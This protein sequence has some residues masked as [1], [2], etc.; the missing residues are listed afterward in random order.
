MES[1]VLDKNYL[2]LIQDLKQK[3]LDNSKQIA[4]R[5]KKF[6]IV[7]C[8]N[9]GKDILRISETYNG[10]WL[11]H[12]FDAVV[13][14]ELFPELN[15]ISINQIQT[16]LSLQLEDGHIP[17]MV[18]L[19]DGKPIAKYSQIQECYSFVQVCIKAIEQNDCDKEQILKIYNALCKWDNWYEKFRM[20]KDGLFLTFC[21][22]DTGHDG[23][24]RLKDYDKY[25]YNFEPTGCVMPTD[26]AVLPVISLDN[27]AVVY[28]NRKGLEQ[29]ANSLG[30]TEQ[31]KVWQTKAEKLKNALL[32]TCYDPKTDFYYDVDKNGNF[33]DIKS[34]SVCA[35]FMHK[36]LGKEEGKN[37]FIKYFTNPNYFGT[38]YPYPSVAVCDPLFEKNSEG[39]SWNYFAQGLT[40][41]RATTWME[42]YG[43]EQYQTLNMQKWLYSMTVNDQRKFA[44][45]LDPFTGEPSM[46]S[47]YYSSSMLYYLYCAKKLFS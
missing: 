18:G 44:Q 12:A 30:L 11:E 8:F 42:Y 26:N 36:V 2:D 38:E 43:L 4:D 14:A 25:K 6:N 10:L 22:Y 17:F 27:N 34:I 28:G 16:F 32:K 9:N 46:Y 13:F 41:L 3:I 15:H 47:E 19:N 37:F 45:E 35:L 1:V 21:G 40:M 29:F 23:S 33:I 39:N 7:D 5:L 20:N 31:A 24:N